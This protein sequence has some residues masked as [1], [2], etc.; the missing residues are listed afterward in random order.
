MR[1]KILAIVLNKFQQFSNLLITISTRKHFL[2]QH[3]SS[4]LKTLHSSPN[5]S[6]FQFQSLQVRREQLQVQRSSF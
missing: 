2:F 4:V 3:K 1:W 5:R 6:N